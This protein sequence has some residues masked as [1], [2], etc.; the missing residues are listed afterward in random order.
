[1]QYFYAAFRD[2]FYMFAFGN[3]THKPNFRHPALHRLSN[4]AQTS[5]SQGAQAVFTT[6]S[7]LFG[8]RLWPFEDQMCVKCSLYLWFWWLAAVL[9]S[10]CEESVIHSQKNFVRSS[11]F[12][13]YRTAWCC[14]LRAQKREVLT[15]YIGV[16]WLEPLLRSWR[17]VFDRGGLTCV[18]LGDSNYPLLQWN[19]YIPHHH[20]FWSSTMIQRWG[21]DFESKEEKVFHW[22]L[23]Y[24]PE[25][26]MLHSQRS[27]Q[28]QS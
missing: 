28:P 15:T 11:V 21:Q 5:G 4:V 1:M 16:L 17:S 8:S 27:L 14:F 7:V 12:W 25:V 20:S 18:V 23:L 3:V 2:T 6:P 13:E 24:N 9:S 26:G 19:M 10:V 22:A